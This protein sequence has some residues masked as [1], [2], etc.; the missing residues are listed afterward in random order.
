MF[1]NVEM[2]YLHLKYTFYVLVF[3]YKFA[4]FGISL[5]IAIRRAQCPP[6]SSSVVFN[7]LTKG[8]RSTDVSH[9]PKIL[10][11]NWERLRNNHPHSFP[12]V[13]VLSSE[14]QARCLAGQGCKKN[15]AVDSL[16]EAAQLKLPKALNSQ[17][18]ISR[19]MIGQKTKGW[20]GISRGQAFTDRLVWWFP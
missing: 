6:C 17:E 12:A 16:P 10:W 19:D 15:T 14:P 11:L 7:R 5:D 8:F 1:S 18:S 20:I 2:S 9:D 4:D 13:P 3:W